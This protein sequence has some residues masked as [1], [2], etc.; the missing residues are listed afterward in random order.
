MSRARI[1]EPFID[2]HLRLTF[3]RVHHEAETLQT[4]QGFNLAINETVALQHGFASAGGE[5]QVFAIALDGPPFR[6]IVVIQMFATA[7]KQATTPI[8]L[9]MRRVPV[10][11]QRV[12][13]KPLTKA[14]AMF[15]VKLAWPKETVPKMKLNEAKR[16]KTAPRNRA[17]E[18]AGSCFQYSAFCRQPVA[19]CTILERLR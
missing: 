15:E 5:D 2:R 1:G 10:T 8:A 17:V 11:A 7:C 4:G 18:S 14:K 9:N 6:K 19:I 12:A 13:A 3:N 16:Q